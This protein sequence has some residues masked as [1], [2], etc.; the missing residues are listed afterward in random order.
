MSRF[1]AHMG[2]SLGSLLT[3]ECL[4]QSTDIF[5]T[6]VVLYVQYSSCLFIFFLYTVSFLLSVVSLS[7]LTHIKTLIYL[8]WH[9]AQ[10]LSVIK[11]LLCGKRMS[12]STLHGFHYPVIIQSLGT[13]TS[14]V[15]HLNGGILQAHEWC[16]AFLVTIILEDILQVNRKAEGTWLS[17]S[18]CFITFSSWDQCQIVGGVFHNQTTSEEAGQG[19]NLI[20]CQEKV[21]LWWIEFVT[22]TKTKT[23][24]STAKCFMVVVVD[25]F[26]GCS[27]ERLFASE[28]ESKADGQE[29][30]IQVLNLMNNTWG[31]L[32]LL[33]IDFNPCICHA[34]WRD[35]CSNNWRINGRKE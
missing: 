35:Y 34:Q 23:G 20:C 7:P 2:L 21:W 28:M 17:I 26:C 11:R 10:L 22:F 4:T 1:P 32:Y 33:I 12:H 30:N 9:S 16:C 24:R 15:K 25:G 18:A 5:C 27:L 29:G 8:T 19:F 31:L 6:L 14:E 13:G 3:L